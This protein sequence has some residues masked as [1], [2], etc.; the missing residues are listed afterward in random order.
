MSPRL[1]KSL[2]FARFLGFTG[3]EARIAFASE[4]AFHRSQIFG[5]SRSTIEAELTRLAGRPLKLAEET[6]AQVFEHAPKSIA[7][8]EAGE[9]ATRD[10]DIEVK[11]RSHPSVK[12]ILK[13]LGGNIEHIQILEPPT[14]KQQPSLEDDGQSDGAD[15]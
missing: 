14:A 13:H 3:A 8:V 10:N 11:V 2:S 7:E 6:N 1:G 5:M 15:R 4:S 12:A 9:K